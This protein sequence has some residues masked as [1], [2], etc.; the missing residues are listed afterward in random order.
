MYNQRFVEAIYHAPERVLQ[1]QCAHKVLQTEVCD[2]AGEAAV[3]AAACIRPADALLTVACIQTPAPF[4]S[5]CAP[6][7][8][9]RAIQRPPEVTRE[10]WSSEGNRTDGRGGRQQSA[11]RPVKVTSCSVPH[12]SS[13]GGSVASVA[14]ARRPKINDIY[15]KPSGWRAGGAARGFDPAG[16][17]FPR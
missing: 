15:P 3:A 12:R 5:A 16:S 8:Q 17:S 9:K 4:G 2:A 11:E 10:L 13:F 7:V 1:R 14:R 6:F